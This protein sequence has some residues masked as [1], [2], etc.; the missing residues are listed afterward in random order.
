MNEVKV[1]AMKKK[2]LMLI[3]VFAMGVGIH[4]SIDFE[5]DFDMY[6]KICSSRSSFEINKQVCLE[7]EEFKRK[8]D[9]GTLEMEASLKD[10]KMGAEK[11][12]QLIR[13]NDRIVAEK[14]K[15]INANKKLIA[16]SKRRMAILDQ[17]VLNRL[18]TMQYYSDEN[19]IIDIIMGSTSLED[20]MTR[21][22]GLSL[23]NKANIEAIYDLER[24]ARELEEAQKF[25]EDDIEKLNR[26]RKQ[27]QRLLNEFRRKEAELYSN[28]TSG[29]SGAVFNDRIESLDFDKITNTSFGRP[30]RSGVVTAQTW[31]YPFGGFHPGIDISNRVGTPII[32]PGNGAV[33]ATANS[34]SGY[35]KHLL[36]VTKRGNYVYTMIF[37]HLNDF[38]G[39]NGFKRGETI[40]YLGNTGMSTGPHV[41]VE[42]FRHNTAD[43]S[44]VVNQYKKQRDYWFGLGYSGRGDCSKVCRL[45]PTEVFNLRMGQRF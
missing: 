31:A 44:L 33:L 17:D 12:A 16:E 38:K 30:L 2:V 28:M 43:I 26:T 32:A 22:D 11:L 7:F 18:S 24:T 1:I 39:V 23:I 35:G 36:I 5:K 25:L 13:K 8:S 6:E 4:A 27:Q 15:E 10:S 21:I 19:Q 9:S 45:Q 42:V 20:L 29:G 41:H 3:L 40:A 14:E 34:G 37:A